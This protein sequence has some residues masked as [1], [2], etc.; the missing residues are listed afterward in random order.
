MNITSLPAWL[1]WIQYLS[2]VRYGVNVRTFAS[3]HSLKPRLHRHL[4]QSRKTEPVRQY[5][6]N[7][8]GRGYLVAITGSTWQLRGIRDYVTGLRGMLRGLRG[9]Y[10]VY[11]VVTGSTWQSRGLHVCYGVICSAY[12][13]VA[14][15]NSHVDPVTTTR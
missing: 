1:S 10:G 5:P 12:C 9:C 14:P 6:R 7:G 3:F 11:V 4:K 8:V 2:M 15:P 13:E